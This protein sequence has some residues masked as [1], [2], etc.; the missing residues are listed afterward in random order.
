[1]FPKLLSLLAILF[2]LAAPLALSADGVPG[3]KGWKIVP[4]CED[5]APP[6]QTD[7][8]CGFK[9]LMHLVKH[10]IDFAL[11]L[12]MPLAAALFAFAGWLYLASSVDPGKKSKAHKI[13]TSVLWGL[14]FILGAWLIV[15]LISDA[16]LE[17]A[18]KATG[19]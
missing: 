16:L 4:D 3:S 10:L 9:T 17:G 1:M 12:T 5:P 19:I 14:L 18:Y 2:I 13:F 7:K 8:V 11:F 15:K 6:G